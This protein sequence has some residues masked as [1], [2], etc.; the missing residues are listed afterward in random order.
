MTQYLKTILT[1]AGSDPMSGAG[2]QADIKAAASRSVFAL[3]AI[4]VITAQNSK[5]VASFTPVPPDVLKAQLQAITQEVIPDAVK[6]GIIGSVENARVIIDFLRH[7]PE[8]PV[9]LDPVIGSTSGSPFCSPALFDFLITH[10]IPASSVVTPN[11]PEALRLACGSANGFHISDG[12][13]LKKLASLLLHKFKSPAILLKGGHLSTPITSESST[14]SEISVITD[15]LTYYDK[16]EEVCLQFSH[17]KTISPNLHG[18]GCTL[19]SLLA[20]EIALGSPLP[21]AFHTATSIME[22]IICKSIG[23]SL[24]Q[25]SNGPLNLFDFIAERNNGINP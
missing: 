21:E 19:S 14:K 5:G 22:D 6:I 2:I 13:D 17:P 8:I 4:S 16:G 15:T 11:I 7:L 3:S 23:Y 10:L 18:T 24:G 20:S 1:I 12:D 25:S 9:I